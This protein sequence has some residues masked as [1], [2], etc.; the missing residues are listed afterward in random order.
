MSLE[1][2]SEVTMDVAM[3]KHSLFS[4]IS[5]ADYVAKSIIL[6]LVLASIWSWGVILS[7]IFV[8]KSLNNRIILFEKMFWSGQVLD[9]LYENIKNK[10]DNPLAASF[11]SAMNECKRSIKSIVPTDFSLRVGQKERVLQS[12][13]LVRDR[14]LEKLET[15]LVFL[16]TV[17]SY[18]TFVGLLG[19]VWGIMSSFQSIA[20]SKNT[21]LAVVAPGI[22]EA[23]FT[24]ALALFVAI[25]ALLSHGYL[26]SRVNSICNK[27]DD[28]IG[29]LNTL[30]S[31]AIDEGRI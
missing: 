14:E 18:A 16:A 7:K 23:L 28:F 19:T 15:G 12:M 30:L 2:I 29:E 22:A 6:L 9:A 21:T 8:L 11:V 27:I 26:T 3:K 4:M 17:G 10:V 25:P 1:K 20:D 24:T 5:S 13:Y 31:R